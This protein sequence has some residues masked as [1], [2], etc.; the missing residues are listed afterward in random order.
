M[1]MKTMR[2]ANNILENG[3]K[4]SFIESVNKEAKVIMASKTEVFSPIEMILNNSNVAILMLAISNMRYCNCQMELSLQ[5]ALNEVALFA[6]TDYFQSDEERLGY[7]KHTLPVIR[8]F[9]S[10]GYRIIV[11]PDWNNK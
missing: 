7:L 9:Y 5:G 6:M 10:D 2:F 3:T 4:L 11:N 1:N 8:G